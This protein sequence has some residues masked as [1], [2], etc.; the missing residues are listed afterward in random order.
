M[1]LILFAIMV[2]SAYSDDN[3]K[4]ENNCC[5]LLGMGGSSNK[6][7]AMDDTFSDVV[8]GRGITNSVIRS[9]TPIDGQKPGTSGLR[10]KT[11]Q[12]M[13]EN[14]LDNF[15]QSTYSA[16]QESG[17]NISEGRFFN[18]KLIDSTAFVCVDS[19]S[20]LHASEF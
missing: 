18:T 5:S 7:C 11:K 6:H 15:V 10:K 19:N 2:L 13:Q 9:T 20:F 14:Y 17:T 3:D 4:K 12:F 8:V 1:K 16:I